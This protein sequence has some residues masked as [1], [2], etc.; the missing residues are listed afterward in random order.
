MKTPS[1]HPGPEKP[2]RVWLKTN[3]AN[4]MRYVPSGTYYARFRSAGKLVWR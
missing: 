1:K 4:L 3:Y 2:A